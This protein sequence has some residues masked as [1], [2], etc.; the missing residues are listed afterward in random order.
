MLIIPAIDLMGGHAV[1]MTR[2]ER[3]SATV[4]SEEPWNLVKAFVQDGAERIHVV[5]I[6]GAFAGDQSHRA[7]VRRIVAK[8]AV[9]IQV[10]G[11]LREDKHLELAFQNGAHYAVLGTAAVKDPEL[12]ERACKTYPGRIVIAVDAVDG[13]VAVE[14]WAEVSDVSATEL[15]VKAESWGAHAV[16]YTDVSR[17]GTGSGANV[18]ATAAL[19]RAVNIPVIASGGIGSLDDI[20][21]LSREGVQMA[22]IGR[23]LYQKRFS[24]AEAI[25][26]GQG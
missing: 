14:G 7:V 10:G 3:D 17:D 6:D 18:E 21:A 24:L 5:D 12:A 4:Y 20:R 16:L 1:R 26:A 19:T 13:R 23:A 25:A 15:A 8:S 22:V 9:P 2:G 11:G